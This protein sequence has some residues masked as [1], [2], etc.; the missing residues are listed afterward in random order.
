VSEEEE[1]NEERT[2]RRWRRYFI[3][4][5]CTLK[6]VAIIPRGRELLTLFLLRYSTH[7]PSSSLSSIVMSHSQLILLSIGFPP[8]ALEIANKE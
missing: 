6:K 1:E 8:A 4:V 5:G 2:K 7:P 3:W